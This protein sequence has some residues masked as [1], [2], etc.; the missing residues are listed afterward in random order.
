MHWKIK[1]ASPPSPVGNTRRCHL[2]EK[3]ERGERKKREMC[4]KKEEARRKMRN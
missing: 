2:E 3:Y 4:K 1:S